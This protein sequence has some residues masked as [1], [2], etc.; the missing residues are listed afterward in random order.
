MCHCRQ[1]ELRGRIPAGCDGQPKVLAG[2][3]SGNREVPSVG[4][5]LRGSVW[6]E[7]IHLYKEGEELFLKGREAEE[8]YKMQQEAMESDDREGIVAEYLDRLLPDNWNMMDVYQRRAFLGGGEFETEG[9]TGTLGG[10]AYAAWRYGW[11][12]SARNGRT[13]GKWILMKSRA[14]S[15]RSAAGKN[16]TPTARGKTKVPLYGV[17]KTFVR[18]TSETV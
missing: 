9:I 13:C 1:H 6:A 2:P 17:Q 18:A 10:S 12:A 3:R 14:S 15:I 7:A 8:A 16:M 5:G 4:A 11:S